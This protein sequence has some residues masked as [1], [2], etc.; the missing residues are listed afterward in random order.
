MQTV[1]LYGAEITG[2]AALHAAIARQLD[3][4]DWYGANLDALHDLLT[5]RRP[6]LRV[7]VL[8]R[9]ALRE[10]LGEDY[11]LRFLRALYDARVYVEVWE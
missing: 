1:T 10:S 5:E 11:Y 9:E 6:A 4:P 2:R 7:V 3:V 8:G